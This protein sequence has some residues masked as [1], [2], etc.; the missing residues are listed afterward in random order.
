MPAR[1]FRFALHSLVRTLRRTGRDLATN[2]IILRRCLTCLQPFPRRGS[3]GRTGNGETMTIKIFRY[4]KVVNDGHIKSRIV[5][6]CAF[7]RSS[8]TKGLRQESAS[9]ACKPLLT[10][11]ALIRTLLRALIGIPE[12]LTTN[13]HQLTRPLG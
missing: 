9:A 6:N 2:P 11:F 4:A 3:G 12:Y 7:G 1:V 8:G 5:V 13:L 10:L